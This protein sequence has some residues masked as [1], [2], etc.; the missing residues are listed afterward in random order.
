MLRYYIKLCHKLSYKQI[1]VKFRFIIKI[2]KN[3]DENSWPKTFFIKLS[4]YTY[5]ICLI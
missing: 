2:I 1:F 3:I 5:D 4:F